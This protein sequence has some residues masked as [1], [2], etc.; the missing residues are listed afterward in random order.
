M[1]PTL[2]LTLALL[3]STAF[4]GKRG[5]AWPWYN[6]PLNPGVLAGGQTSF[7][8]D[9][10][11][12]AP[13]S[14]NGNG[15]LEFIGMQGCKDCDSSPVGD[16]KNRANAQK[17]KHLF[18]LNEPDING[19]SPGDAASWYKTNIAS[20]SLKKALPAVT[21]STNAGQGLDWLSQMVK[22][23]GN[24]CPAAYIN[25]HWYGNNFNEFQ[26]FIQKAHQQFGGHDIVISEFALAKPAGG[27]QAQVDFF[28]QA[29]TWLDSQNY[30]AMY[31]PFVATSPQLLQAND[32]GA[33]NH[34]GTGSTLY[35]NDGS[36]SAVGK[37][38]K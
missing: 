25:V 23:C 30:V 36:A 31:F 37:L 5:L 3:A 10:E 1:I 16:L 13:P 27:Q 17:W 6:K 18:T 7:I 12:Y 32:Q 9:W 19:I 4:A 8:Y 35:S 20:L 15:G 2:S 14:S 21:S 34:V 33:V 26:T 29:F 38:M 22:A 28:R 24:G 11:T